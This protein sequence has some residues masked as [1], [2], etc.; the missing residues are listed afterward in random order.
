MRAR[1]AARVVQRPKDPSIGDWMNDMTRKLATVIVISGL[2]IVLAAPRASAQGHFEFGAHYGPW[3]LNLLKPV[4]ESA[5]QELG[6][7]ITQKE[8]DKIR[9]DYPSINFRQLGTTTQVQFDSS[10]SNYGFDVR[11]YPQGETGGFSIGLAAEKSTFTVGLPNVSSSLALEDV[12][13]HLPW[14]FTGQ[15]KGQVE[16]S[17]FAA[18][19]SFRW[20]II[21]SAWMHPYLTLGFGAAGVSAW[22]QTTLNYSYT[23]LLSGPGGLT[24]SITESSGKSLLQLKQEYDQKVAAGDPDPGPKPFEYPTIFPMVQLNVGLKARVAKK[25]SVLV[26]AGVLNGFQ[27]RAGIGIRP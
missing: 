19:L 17:P 2:A 26:D 24:V 27:L 23:G 18:M 22:E 16:A 15:A 1:G 4:I 10:G 5:V 13:N 8:L 12:K 21:P 9:K 6:E 11:W 7:Q 14:N 20:D 25:F 3:S